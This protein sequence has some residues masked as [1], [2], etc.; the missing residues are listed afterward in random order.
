VR[1][2]LERQR[3]QELRPRRAG[4]LD[5]GPRLAREAIDQRHRGTLSD[6]AISPAELLAGAG[7]RAEQRLPAK[8]PALLQAIQFWE[9]LTFS[10]R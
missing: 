9:V 8:V 6:G 3:A 7:N 5:T 4:E 1:G 2:E 10:N